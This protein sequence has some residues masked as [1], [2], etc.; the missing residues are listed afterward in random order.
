MQSG[1]P[2]YY[3]TQSRQSESVAARYTALL[4]CFRK[5]YKGDAN[6]KDY[7]TIKIRKRWRRMFGAERSYCQVTLILEGSAISEMV[8]FYSPALQIS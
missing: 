7:L 4:W 1:P 8:R 5:K 3:V 6:A 2:E